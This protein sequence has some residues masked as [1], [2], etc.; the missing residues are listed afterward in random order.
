MAGCLPGFLF[1]PAQCILYPP[2]KEE[3]RMYEDHLYVVPFAKECVAIARVQTDK[4][5]SVV[6]SFSEV[7]LLEN[8][9]NGFL[10]TKI[11]YRINR[12]TLLACFEGMN[13]PVF[14]AEEDIILEG[15]TANL[16]SLSLDAIAVHTK[17]DY[18]F[19]ISF[20]S[21]KLCFKDYYQIPNPLQ[22]LKAQSNQMDYAA[23][24]ARAYP[25][26]VQMYFDKCDAMQIHH[27]T[28]QKKIRKAIVRSL[29]PY[30][31]IEPIQKFE[32]KRAEF[33]AYLFWLKYLS[34]AK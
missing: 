13:F 14:A 24:Y 33:L 29:V 25:Y 12:N 7:N 11:P 26:Q 3:T 1:D 23:L 30:E 27:I 18:D 20:D 10:S 6:I 17:N 32:G 34:D 16:L 28:G 2:G 8:V 15:Y 21:F 9:F 19:R 5:S 4:G 31:S 22:V